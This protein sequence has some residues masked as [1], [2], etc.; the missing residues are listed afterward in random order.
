MFEIEDIVGGKCVEMTTGG[1]SAMVKHYLVKWAGYSSKFNSW[2]P[3]Q[4]FS[5]HVDTVQMLEEYE[6][7][8][9]VK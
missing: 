2:V 8:K 3:L 4:S 7:Q 1:G 5:S 6:A 9:K